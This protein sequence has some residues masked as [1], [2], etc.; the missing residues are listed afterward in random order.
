MTGYAAQRN[1]N[2]EVYDCAPRVF[3]IRNMRLR[4][5][6]F[7]ETATIQKQRSH[8]KPYSRQCTH[9]DRYTRTICFCDNTPLSQVWA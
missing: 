8:K 3:K 9:S 2:H 7:V 6:S 1:V 4:C 5:G